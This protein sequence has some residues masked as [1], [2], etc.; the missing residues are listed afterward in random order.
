MTGMRTVLASLFVLG[1]AGTGLAFLAPGTGSSTAVGVDA[2][3][4]SCSSCDARHQRLG[5]LDTSLARDAP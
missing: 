2:P 4:S 1:L 5:K 3:T